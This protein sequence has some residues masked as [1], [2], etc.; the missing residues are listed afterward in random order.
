MTDMLATIQPK[1]DQLNADD[2]IGGVL[3]VIKVT[4]VSRCKQPEQPIAIG[5]EGDNG[6][7]Y[8]PC[9]S[10]RRVMVNVW[11][12][13]GASYVGRSMELYRDDT[14]KFAGL[15][16]GGIRISRMSDIS[17][18]VTMALTETRASKKPFTVKPLTGD[19][20]SNRKP[21]TAKE[22][23]D[24]L[25]SRFDSAVDIDTHNEIMTDDL[26]IRQINWLRDKHPALHGTVDHAVSASLARNTSAEMDDDTSRIET[27]FDDDGTE[28]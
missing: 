9:K 14:V 24:A 28:P 15:D 17:K 20:D 4:S 27:P 13:D 5:F 6:K 25:V 2:L 26:V 19:R 7:P 3:K 11:G 8:K 18:P 10:M 12:P 16:V 21:P 23:A 22:I 1:S